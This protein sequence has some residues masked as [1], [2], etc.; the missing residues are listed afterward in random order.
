EVALM[1]SVYVSCCMRRFWAG[2]ASGSQALA[3]A[4]EAVGSVGDNSGAAGGPS[5][6]IKPSTIISASSSLPGNR[7]CMPCRVNQFLPMSLISRSLRFECLT[8]STKYFG[9]ETRR[10]SSTLF[11][12]V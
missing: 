2:L 12:E 7:R 9:R 10:E 11:F 8:H 3:A 6:A 1:T 4:G 5:A